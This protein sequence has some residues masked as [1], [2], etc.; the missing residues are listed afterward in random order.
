[1]E[2]RLALT[3][4]VDRVV[5]L[6][7]FAS[8]DHSLEVSAIVEDTGTEELFSQKADVFALDGS[9]TGAC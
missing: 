4:I 5:P 7:C 9:G 2:R 6:L 1:M 8:S 3:L